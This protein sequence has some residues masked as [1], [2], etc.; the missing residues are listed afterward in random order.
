VEKTCAR[1]GESKPTTA[2]TV[3]SVGKVDC[4]CRPCRAEYGREHYEKHRR[5]Y[6]TQARRRKD[7]VRAENYRQL[8][9]YLREHPC[10]DCGEDDV[11]VLEFDHVSGKAYNI[12]RGL[13]HR[14]WADVLTEIA[15]CEVVCANCHRRRTAMRGGWARVVAAQDAEGNLA[16]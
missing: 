1:C 10:V 8:I 3:S 4:Y 13:S 7:A 11:L 6:I 15:K 14:W 9:R 2:Y 5:R 12:A 16:T